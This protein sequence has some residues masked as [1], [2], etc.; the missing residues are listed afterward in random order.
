MEVRWIHL[1]MKKKDAS[2]PYNKGGIIQCSVRCSV[3]QK[4]E[5]PKKETEPIKKLLSKA[6]LDV[7]TNKN[8]IASH[9]IITSKNSIF[10]YYSEW[11][12]YLRTSK[13]Y[14][15]PRSTRPRS[16]S[17]CRKR[18][19]S[20]SWSSYLFT[21]AKSKTKMAF[22]LHPPTRLSNRPSVSGIKRTPLDRPSALKSTLHTF[23]RSEQCVCVWIGEVSENQNLTAIKDTHKCSVSVFS[24][25]RVRLTLEIRAARGRLPSDLHSTVVHPSLSFSLRQYTAHYCFCCRRPFSFLLFLF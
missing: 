8:I 10:C 13:S 4:R 17:L 12:R 11:E 25:G 7:K 22:H 5:H 24:L 19:A 6:K 18:K 3:A 1:H 2:N 16:V 23:A 21:S 15:L 9:T 14:Y 20:L